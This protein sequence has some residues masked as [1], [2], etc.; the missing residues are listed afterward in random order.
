MYLSIYRY[1]YL[2]IDIIPINTV[3]IDT[4]RY[5]KVSISNKM[6]IS[7]SFFKTFINLGL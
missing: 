4:Y 7:M 2:S 6:P 3:S 1:L 5:N